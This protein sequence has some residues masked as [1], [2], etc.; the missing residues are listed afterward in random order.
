MPGP[1][2]GVRVVELA[3]LA[4][5]PFGCMLLADLGAEVTRIDR[6]GAHESLVSPSG[7]LDR[8]K[9]ALALDLKDPADLV[10]ALELIDDAD[11]FVEALRPGVAERL[12]VGP[13]ELLA[14]NPRLV[15]GRMTGWGQDGPLAAG[16]GH[17]INYIALAG[18]LEP[19]GRAGDRPYAAL[20][21][22]G[23]FAGGGMLLA[24]GVLAALHERAQSGRGQVVDA[25]MVDGAS[26]LMS[27]VHGM[28]ANG[29]WEGERGTNMLD[30]GAPFYD[31]YECADGKYVAV[32]CVEPHFYQQMLAILEVDEEAEGLDFQHDARGWDKARTV[33]AARFKDRTRAEWATIFADTDA[34]VTPVLS[35]WEAHEHAHHKARAS[36]VEVDGLMQ[37]APAPRFSRTPTATPAPLRRQF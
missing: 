14:R 4:P 1:L 35:P 24:L 27:F 25:A 36:F 3:G 29:L 2:A 28:R 20:N 8:G 26:V 16:A 22:L 12:G 18:A 13:D 30:G 33:L 6:G 15:Y 11:V 23:D 5:A 9:S 7:P 31:T 21:L 19:V 32:G 10:R 17:D 37:P 34:C